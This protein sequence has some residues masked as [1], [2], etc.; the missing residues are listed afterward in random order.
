MPVHKKPRASEIPSKAAFMY[1]SC[2]YSAQSLAY[3][4]N[5]CNHGLGAS[6]Q[7]L[8]DHGNINIYGE[9]QDTHQ[10]VDSVNEDSPEV[11]PPLLSLL[12]MV[13]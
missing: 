6:Y 10:V 3:K 12:E 4:R 11:A 13:L 8:K 5:W 1:P 9:V 7:S 2:M